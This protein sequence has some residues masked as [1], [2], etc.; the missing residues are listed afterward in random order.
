[1]AATYPKF[2]LLTGLTCPQF[3][4]EGS[5]ESG[6]LAELGSLGAVGP[7]HHLHGALGDPLGYVGLCLAAAW[8][9]LGLGRPDELETIPT[10]LMLRRRHL[11]LCHHTGLVGQRNGGIL[12][13]V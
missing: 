9:V 7:K 1:M 4:R 2:L 3:S 11:T 13:A 10:G 5:A 12:D 8:A 6:L